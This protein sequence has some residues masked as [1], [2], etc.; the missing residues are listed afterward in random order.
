MKCQYHQNQ[1]EYGRP[2]ASYFSAGAFMLT[3]RLDAQ[4]VVYVRMRE[5]QKSI[6]DTLFCVYSVP[7][8]PATKSS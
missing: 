5:S 7:L 3:P 4:Q 8:V 2:Y 6:S 1:Y